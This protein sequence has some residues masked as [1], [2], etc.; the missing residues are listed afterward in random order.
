MTARDRAR[1]RCAIRGRRMFGVVAAQGKPA[2]GS[3]PAV[4]HWR[5]FQALASR[6]NVRVSPASPR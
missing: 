6:D 2:R 4:L 5:T 3:M 1:R